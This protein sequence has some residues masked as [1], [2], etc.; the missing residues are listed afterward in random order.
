MDIFA[1]STQTVLVFGARNLFSQVSYNTGCHP[2]YNQNLHYL[3][4][5]NVEC[6]DGEVLT[7]FQLK[8][9]C[10][11]SPD[12]GTIEFTCASLR[13]EETPARCD[14][15]TGWVE[16]QWWSDSQHD[17]G[18]QLAYDE[19]ILYLDRHDIKCPPGE[20]LADFQ[21]RFNC[22]GDYARIEYTCRK[23]KNL[24][25]HNK[26]T[27]HYTSCNP[28]NEN[29][30][31]LDRFQVSCPHGKMLKQW[32]MSPAGCA[33]DH[34]RIGYWCCQPLPSLPTKY[35]FVYNMRD[36]VFDKV[37]ITSIETEKIATQRNGLVKNCASGVT[38]TKTLQMSLDIEDS[39]TLT[40]SKSFT[41]ALMRSI[42]AG[43][44]LYVET[45]I[46]AVS[47]VN[48]EYSNQWQD[49]ATSEDSKTLESSQTIRIEVGDSVNVE[50]ETCAQYT[51]FTFVS[52]SPVTV[53]YTA[54]VFLTVFEYDDTMGRGQ[55][56]S[57]VSILTCV[58]D[59][60][61]EDGATISSGQIVYE[62]D[63]DYEGLYVAE[64]EWESTNCD[65]CT[66]SPTSAPTEHPTTTSTEHLTTT[67]ANT[68]TLQSSPT[69]QSSSTPT[70]LSLSSPTATAISDTEEENEE[71]SPSAS[72]VA[73]M[74]KNWVALWCFCAFL[75][76][77][78]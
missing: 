17:T 73:V 7:G 5:H 1:N 11:N 54:N 45:A 24:I 69:L 56:V 31:Y 12:L 18:C 23:V 70:L 25:L 39:Q 53:P 59:L 20:L 26:C 44:E 16:P 30:H 74:N 32:K 38:L 9:G 63:G 35:D 75:P 13:T 48:F 21:M 50:P 78:L 36:F 19:N 33:A 77:I 27:Q 15:S 4:R 42:T 2:I 62:I 72:S 71:I 29:L 67:P 47:K 37:D 57:D 10:S 34:Q 55:Q 52:S 14:G 58:R 64:E 3:D 28:A 49:F 68:L 40:V 8:L 22:G 61:N 66:A 65:Y 51:L 60:L 41:R 43:V 6:S 76:V 46:A